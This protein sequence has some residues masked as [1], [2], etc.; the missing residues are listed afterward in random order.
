MASHHRQTLAGEMKSKNGK[1]DEDESP[2]N[3]IQ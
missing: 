2:F 1:I 3:Q